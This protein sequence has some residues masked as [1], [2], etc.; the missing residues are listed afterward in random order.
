MKK[1]LLTL[2][3]VSILSLV[4]CKKEE[5]NVVA[6]EKSTPTLIQHRSDK[7]GKWD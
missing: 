4:S 2:V 3:S 7:L 5:N 6:K 1:I